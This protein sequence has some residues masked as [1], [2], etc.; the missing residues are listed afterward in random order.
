MDCNS[1]HHVVAYR[2]HTLHI[3]CEVSIAC[4]ASVACSLSFVVAQFILSHE[5]I[6]EKENYYTVTFLRNALQ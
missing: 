1:L 5:A 4:I 2:L 6:R 3:G